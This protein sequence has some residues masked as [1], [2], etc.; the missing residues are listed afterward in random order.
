MVLV[1]EY[2]MP[3]LKASISVSDFGKRINL[4]EQ[5]YVKLDY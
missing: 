5:I 3:P 1:V 4:N 2:G